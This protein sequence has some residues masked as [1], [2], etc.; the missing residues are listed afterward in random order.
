MNSYASIRDY[1]QNFYNRFRCNNK[2]EADHDDIKTKATEEEPVKQAQK[3]EAKETVP[4]TDKKIESES[5]KFNIIESDSIESDSIESNSNENKA[6]EQTEKNQPVTQNF[7]PFQTHTHEFEASTKF[8]DEDD[9]R[10]NHRFAGVT[11]EAIPIPGTGHKHAVFSFTDFYGHLHEVA[12]ET[13]PAI[14]IGGS[15][16]IHF[17]SGST[18]IND[19]HYH[20]FEFVTLIEAPLLPNAGDC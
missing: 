12:A 18:T 5:D 3:T 6:N 1:Q 20:D 8:A 2:S 14:P 15:K 7:V 9:D 19:G 16:H 13:G 17:I 4:E 11:S 10:H